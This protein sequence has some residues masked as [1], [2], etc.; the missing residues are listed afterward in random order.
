LFMMSPDSEKVN[1]RYVTLVEGAAAG[2]ERRR[3]TAEARTWRER[4]RALS[5]RY[6]TK[7]GEVT[8]N[9]AVQSDIPCRYE[10]RREETKRFTPLRATA[11]ERVEG[12]QVVYSRTGRNGRAYVRAEPWHARRRSAE[13]RVRVVAGRQVWQV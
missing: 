4:Q 12:A 3:Q 1:A 6:A 8:Q 5:A 9:A 2:A 13:G 10:N 7:S 11:S